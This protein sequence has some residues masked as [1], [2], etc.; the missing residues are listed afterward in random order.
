MSQD[1]PFAKLGALDQKLY[2]ETTPKSPVKEVE[3]ATAKEATTNNQKSSMPA[4]QQAGKP[5]IRQTSKLENQKSGKPEIQHA[6]NMASQ[7]AGNTEI[8][9]AGKTKVPDHITA[10]EKVTYRFHSEGKYAV[11]DMKTILARKHGIKASLEEIAEEAILIAYE[12]L[13]EN[14]NASKLANRLSRIPENQ[15]SS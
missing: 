9:Q 11:E 1:N 14:Q 5:E 6:S 2:Q 4:N 8:R 10:T 15:K 3:R 13:L 7:K 12:D